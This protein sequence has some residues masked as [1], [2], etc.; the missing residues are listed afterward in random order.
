MGDALAWYRENVCE[1]RGHDH[2]D[3]GELD[4]LLETLHRLKAGEDPE[5]VFNLGG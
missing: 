1:A 3:E 4:C 2:D 5:A